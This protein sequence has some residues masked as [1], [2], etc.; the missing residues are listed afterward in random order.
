MPV[1]LING[2]VKR[3]FLCQGERLLVWRGLIMRIEVG[4]KEEE[5]LFSVEFPGGKLSQVEN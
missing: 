4:T 3:F 2:K 1:T 5:K